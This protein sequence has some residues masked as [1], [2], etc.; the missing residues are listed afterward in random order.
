LASSEVIQ[1]NMIKW[2]IDAQQIW[3]QIK[4]ISYRM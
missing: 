4:T 3:D 1:F 2:Y